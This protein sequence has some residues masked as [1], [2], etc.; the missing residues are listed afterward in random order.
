[1]RRKIHCKGLLDCRCN[2]MSVSVRILPVEKFY[3]QSYKVSFVGGG[4]GEG[5]GGGGGGGGGSEVSGSIVHCGVIWVIQSG[6]G[7]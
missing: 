5:G 6:V 3:L 2:A 7:S 4:G 1:M